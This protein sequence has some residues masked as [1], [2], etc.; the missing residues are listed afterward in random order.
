MLGDVESMDSI[1]EV[2]YFVEGI[3]LVCI[4]APVDKGNTVVGD[5]VHKIAVEDTSDS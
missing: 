4:V 1:L 3:P 2:A 5:I